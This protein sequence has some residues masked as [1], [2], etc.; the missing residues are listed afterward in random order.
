MCGSVACRADGPEAIFKLLDRLVNEYDIRGSKLGTFLCGSVACRADKPEAIFKL[1]DRLVK[2][3][4][5]SRLKLGT[6]M[7]N[8]VARKADELDDV[9]DKLQEI[10]CD[11]VMLVGSNA[12]ASRI[13]D[14]F[15]SSVLAIFRHMANN[16]SMDDA[17]ELMRKTFNK[18]AARLMDGIA[19]LVKAVLDIRDPTTLRAFLGQFQYSGSRHDEYHKAVSRFLA[20]AEPADSAASASV[21]KRPALVCTARA[22]KRKSTDSA[23]SASAEKRPALACT[24][25]ANERKAASSTA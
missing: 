15:I 8:S 6:F 3:Y 7:C 25:R 10:G 21:E 24:A 18:N 19:S 5:I 14:T 9:L 1:L 22:N 2:E 13:N 17:S 23:A 16:L 12:F 4:D 11:G 20:Q